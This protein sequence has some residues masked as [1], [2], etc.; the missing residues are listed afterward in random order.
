MAYLR[1][2]TDTTQQ[3][4]LA[5][6]QTAAW[7]QADPDEYG[8]AL[9]IDEPPGGPVV[10]R[11]SGDLDVVTAPVLGAC[12][13]EVVLRGRSVVVDLLPTGFV[14]C[15]VLSVLAAAGDRLRDQRSR[16]TVAAPGD[17]RRII[18][19]VGID[20][21]QCFA[22]VAEAFTAAHP[23]RAGSVV[24]SVPPLPMLD[25][26]TPSRHRPVAARRPA[27]PVG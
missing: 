11:V 26:P 17:L 6:A 16:L 1:S 27:Q 2:I 14:G 8:F 10:L 13:D 4:C 7:D 20:A 22:S 9:Q 18:V 24:N 23:T 19:A 15:A 21:V 5:M 25:R 3:F 12:L